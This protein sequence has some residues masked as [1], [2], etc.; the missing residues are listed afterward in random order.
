MKFNE[1]QPFWTEMTQLITQRN[2]KLLTN[3]VDQFK[4]PPTTAAE[5]QQE[6]PKFGKRRSTMRSSLQNEIVFKSKN[7]KKYRVAMRT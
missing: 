2:N 4:E 5:L 1:Q 3:I 7:A 6:A